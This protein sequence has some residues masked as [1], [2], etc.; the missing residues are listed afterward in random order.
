MLQI[1]GIM[2]VKYVKMYKMDKFS[3]EILHNLMYI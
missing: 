1:L 3:I 2:I